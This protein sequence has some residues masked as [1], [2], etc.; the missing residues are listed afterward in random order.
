MLD[1]VRCAVAHLPP[2]LDTNTGI[3]QQMIFSIKIQKKEVQI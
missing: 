2:M 3:P 1:A